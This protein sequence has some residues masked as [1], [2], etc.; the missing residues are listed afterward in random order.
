MT[1]GYVYKEGKLVATAEFTHDGDADGAKVVDFKAELSI[2]AIEG[3][4]EIVKAQDSVML[5]ALLG[6]IQEGI[7]S[8]PEKQG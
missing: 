5:K 8:I 6:V 7:R 3:V 1:K 2:D 4:K